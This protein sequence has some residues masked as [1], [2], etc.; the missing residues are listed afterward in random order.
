MLQDFDCY[1]TTAA[2]LV[3]PPL[4]PVSHTRLK[5]RRKVQKREMKQERRRCGGQSGEK[6]LNVR[7]WF[8]FMY[9]YGWN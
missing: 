6:E 2:A 4:S 7:L 3:P 8:E 1:P 9:A 5:R